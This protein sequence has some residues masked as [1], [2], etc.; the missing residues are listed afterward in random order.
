[1]PV[2]F[3]FP[4]SGFDTLPF[5]IKPAELRD[6]KFQIGGNTI[7]ISIYL[8]YAVNFFPTDSADDYNPCPNAVVRYHLSEITDGDA[9]PDADNPGGAPPGQFLKAFYPVFHHGE[10]G[11][12]SDGIPEGKL[13]EKEQVPKRHICAVGPDSIHGKTKRYR[14]PDGLLKK[15]LRIGSARKKFRIDENFSDESPRKLKT[16]FSFS[17][18]IV[19]WYGS[20]FFGRR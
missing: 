16:W 13:C 2:I 5:M 14:S 9:F 15:I 7:I 1:M 3:Q 4:E 8:P 12:G 17:F 18:F 20:L 19:S 6:G 10:T 11:G